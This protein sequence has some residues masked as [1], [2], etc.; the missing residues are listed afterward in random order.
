MLINKIFLT[1]LCSICITGCSYIT[2]KREVHYKS[3]TL[4]IEEQSSLGAPMITSELTQYA[5]GSRKYD[6][7]E[8]QDQ[9]QSFEYP[10]GHLFKEQLIYSGRSENIISISY[11]LYK[12]KLSFPSFS[13]E[14]TYDLDHSDIIEF[15]NYKIKVL[16]ATNEYI[17]FLVLAD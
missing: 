4:N 17:R 3:Y 10:A 5:G 16:N 11:K 7:A 2:T 15:K 12:K 8:E 14:L 13:Q 9:W 1:V 6:L